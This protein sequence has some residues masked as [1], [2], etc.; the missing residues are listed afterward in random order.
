MVMVVVG[1]CAEVSFE[2]M[3]CAVSWYA[4]PVVPVVVGGASPF[5]VNV[6]RCRAACCACRAV[7][8]RSIVT[9]L[10]CVPSIGNASCN[11]LLLLVALLLVAVG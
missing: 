2:L 7:P 4:Q 1:R 3:P 9:V 5:M 6:A 11:L 10:Y 8:L